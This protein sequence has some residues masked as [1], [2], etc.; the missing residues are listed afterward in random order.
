VAAMG[1]I[2]LTL[3]NELSSN[4][5]AE[6]R[7]RQAR[8]QLEAYS[9]LI[10]TRRRVEDFDRQ[11]ADICEIIVAH[12]RFTQA[13][14]LFGTG[15]RYRLAGSAGLDSAIVKALGALLERIPL[16][17]FLEPG[18]APPAAEGSRTLQLDLSPW[19]IPG[20]DLERLHF[21]SVLAVPMMSRSGAEGA[22]LLSGM[23]AA[24]GHVPAPSAE[25]PRVDDL[26]PIELL[27]ARAQATR[28]RTMLFEKLIDSEKYASLGQLAGN[29]TQQLN[30]PLTVILGYTALLQESASLDAQ[31]RKA[32]AS[33]MTESRRI[34]STLESLA[35]ISDTRGDLSTAVSVP[36]LLAD[37]EQLYRFEFLQRSIEF[38]VNVAPGLPRVLCGAQ[39]LRRAVLHCLQFAADAVER[40]R[41]LGSR[42]EVKTIRLDA[43]KK[44]DQ[45]Q[46]SISHSGPAFLQPERAFDPFAP[47][48]PGEETAGLGLS[49]CASILRDQNGRALARNL[50]PSG[51]AIILELP[52]A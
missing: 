38:Q 1:M 32:V 25:T 4:K 40:D 3:E 39:Q 19:L 16:A 30:N 42:K 21:T 43:G 2:L 35:R 11:G 27:A 47:S 34:R 6:A 9:N 7:E 5:L 12:S 33:I 46:I 26:L 29:V 31:N 15:G 44:N 23:R 10:L 8:R 49:L 45:V 24:S 37:M 17:G 22:L 41:D 13:A 14:L 50:E 48:Q 52:S 28:S 20:D 18:S 36:E 51:A